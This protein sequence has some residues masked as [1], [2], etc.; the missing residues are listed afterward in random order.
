MFFWFLGP[1]G[2]TLLLMLFWP[3]W[4][5]LAALCWGIWQLTG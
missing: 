2:N 5:M 1:G 3:G 4:L